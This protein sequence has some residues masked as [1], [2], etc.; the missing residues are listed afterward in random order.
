MASSVISKQARPKTLNDSLYRTIYSG[1][2]STLKDY[3]ERPQNIATGTFSS[4]DTP[5]TFPKYKAIKEVYNKAVLYNKILG[6]YAFKADVRYRLQVNATRFQQGRYILAWIPSG[7]DNGCLTTDNF[8]YFHAHNKGQITQLPHVE[9][10]LSCDTEVELVIPYTSYFMAM[11]QSNSAVAGM[12]IGTVFIYPY[13]PL[14]AP[15]G[16]LV[17][18]YALWANFENITFFGSAIPQS[19]MKMQ[20]KGKKMSVSQE[21]AKSAGKGALST[22]LNG[23]ATF[24]GTL[25]MIPMLTEIAAPVSWVAGILGQTAAAFGWSKP[26]DESAAMRVVRQPQPFFSNVDVVDPGMKLSMLITNS[27]DPLPGFASTDIDEMSIDYIKSIPAY[28]NTITWNTSNVAG[29]A[30]C[31]YK[32]GP[33][34]L[35]YTET[36]L[37]GTVSTLTPVMYLAKGFGYWRGSIKY[38]FK[39]V[40]TEFHSGRLLVSFNPVNATYVGAVAPTFISNSN[41]VIR[42]IFDVRRGNEFTVTVPYVNYEN[43]SEVGATGYIGYLS[44]LVLDPLIAPSTVSSTITCLV[45]ASA[46]DDFELAAPTGQTAGHNPILVASYQSAMAMQNIEEPCE[47]SDIVL[48]GQTS[49]DSDT[50]IAPSFSCIG[51]KILSLRQYLK[52]FSPVVTVSGTANSTY[53][54]ADNVATSY[55]VNP[56]MDVNIDI[57]D[58]AKPCV[59]TAD[60]FTYFGS[61][62]GLFRGSIRY[63]M[64]NLGESLEGSLCIAQNAGPFSQMNYRNVVTSVGAQTIVTMTRLSG[65]DN[66]AIGQVASNAGIEVT[67]PFYNKNHSIPVRGMLINGTTSSLSGTNLSGLANTAPEAPHTSLTIG[68]SA[69]NSKYCLFRAIG[70]DASFGRFISTPIIAGNQVST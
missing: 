45:E 13:A 54:V 8:N 23:I 63:R 31:N 15:A 46:G 12:D 53:L 41:Y 33:T 40:K 17:C 37:S 10:D 9:I 59:Y 65:F 36:Q 5:T 16:S 24:A 35:G 29:D 52:R 55:I 56:L 61:M 7:G 70:E 11:G 60:P 38:T 3:L 68:L 4:T 66:M 39:F 42:E 18:D 26:A 1:Q 67:S 21:E 27:I 62:F 25:S 51:E 69:A 32:V 28:F 58:A 2:E 34:F 50:I 48:G 64:T 20:R 44:A 57:A 43:W 47:V 19:G 30:L 14:A 49:M 22:T 6:R